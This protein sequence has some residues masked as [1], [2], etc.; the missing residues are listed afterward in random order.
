MD[1]FHLLF[2]QFNTLLT[3][4]YVALQTAFHVDPDKNFDDD[5][6][7]HAPCKVSLRYQADSECGGPVPEEH[8]EVMT[9]ITF[10]SPGKWKWNWNAFF[11]QV[12]LVHWSSITSWLLS[13]GEG[14]SGFQSLSVVKPKPKPN[15]DN[16]QSQQT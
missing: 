13:I 11:P 2:Q 3:S 14:Y 8:T 12:V 16:G 10:Y 6:F 9:Q 4:E 5:S 15:Y 1:D 7:Y